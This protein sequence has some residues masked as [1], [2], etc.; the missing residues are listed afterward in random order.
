MTEL[1][2]LQAQLAA[3]NK[4]LEALRAAHSVATVQTPFLAAAAHLPSFTSL[5]MK[6]WF[7]QAEA[8]FAYKGITSERT[9]FYYVTS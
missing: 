8:Q 1:K 7:R 9:K 5:D 4:E 2:N 3:A 6:D